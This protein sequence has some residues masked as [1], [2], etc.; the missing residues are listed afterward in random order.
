M[1]KYHDIVI[2]LAGACQ[3]AA[4]VPELSHNGIIEQK[5]YITAIKSIFNT[6]PVSTTEVFGEVTNIK[7]G[8]QVLI[9]ILN[10][11][12]EKDVIDVTRY[13]FAILN[14]TNHLR[15]NDVALNELSQRL[16][17]LSILYTL[18]NDDDLAH[19]IDTISYS[20]AGIYT[21]IISPLTT[22]I[23]VMG[24][25]EYLQNTLIQA[26]I[27]TILFACVRAS[28]LW[29]QMGGTR[30]QFILSRKKLLQTAQEL[31]ANI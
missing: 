7:H 12:K 11:Q 8:L 23:K 31:L 30:W 28:I 1:G 19:S 17:R 20:L 27:R 18:S 25:M 13:L 6:N 2:A 29:F 9:K 24:K 21:D 22:K 16:S 15:R 10:A 5:Y 3:S 26:K 14:I 4:L